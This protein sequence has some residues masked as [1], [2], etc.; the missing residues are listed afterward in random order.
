MFN[1]NLSKIKK[2]QVDSFVISQELNKTHIWQDLVNSDRQLAN[3]RENKLAKNRSLKKR[4]N[5]PS[6]EEDVNLPLIV[7]ANAP[8][9][10]V[11]P[12]IVVG[13]I[14]KDDNSKL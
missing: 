2:G 12:K 8:N 9:A 13:N 5:P 6:I 3:E 14:N 1:Q 10:P 11:I 7:N 4:K